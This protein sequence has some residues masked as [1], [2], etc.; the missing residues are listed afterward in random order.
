M[1]R[2]HGSPRFV[3]LVFG[4]ALLAGA[5]P[6][7]AVT[8]EEIPSPRPAGWFVDLTGSIPAEIRQQIDR[9]GDEIKAAN[10]AE[11]GVVVIDSTG[12]IPSREFA[13]RLFDHWKIGES[14]ENNGF[15]LF[16]ALGDRRVEIVL[17][18]GLDNPANNQVSAEI[19]QREIIPLLRAGDPG[20]AFLAGTRASARHILDVAPPVAES[21][22]PPAETMVEIP[23]APDPALPRVPVTAPPAP[24]HREETAVP[25]SVINLLVAARPILLLGLLGGVGYLA[26]RAARCRKCGIPMTLLSEREDDAHLTPAER[27]EEKL[28]SVNHLI[29]LCSG[30]GES[31][32]RSWPSLVSK[33]SRC[34]SC[35]AKAAQSTSW[36][37]ASPT[38]SS[39]GERRVD[40]SCAPCDHRTSSTVMI[41]RL[42]ETRNDDSDRWSSANSGSS[43]VA[44][45]GLAASVS[46]FDASSSSSDSGSSGYSG[47]ESSDGG[48][49]GSW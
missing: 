44:S 1:N 2:I 46:S 21:V 16:A 38:Y 22:A 19:M 42:V 11:I 40:T 45:A 23:P 41:P 25:Q 33:Y 32:K 7:F 30:C 36:I 6:I 43:S 28:G 27:T 39:T 12:G 49:S 47:G 24:S 3:C 35:G 5:F 48:A 13:R 20:G 14:G 18:R 17:G 37:V 29:W 15:L 31:R 8:V 26:R 9:L 34:P 4:L 10:G